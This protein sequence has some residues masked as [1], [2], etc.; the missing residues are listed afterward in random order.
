MSFTQVFGGTTLYPSNVSYLALALT[1]DTSLEWPLESNTLTPVAASIIDVSPTGAYAVSMP[2]AT[3]TGVGQTVLF[4][5]LGP[6]TI[7]IKDAGGGTLLSIAAGTQWEVYLVDNTSAAGTWRTFQLGATTAQAQASA[8]AGFGLIATGSTLSVAESVTTFNSNFTLPA[9]ARGAAY[10]WNG[11]LGTVS[12]IA[13][14]TL[15][16]NWFAD[17]RNSGSGNLTIDPA[18]SELINGAATL[19]LSP[20]DS[21]RVVTDGSAWYTFGLGRSAVFAFDY[22][23]ISLTG[24]TSP[25]TLSGSEL[26]RVAYKFTGVLTA[27]M[28]I[29]VPSTTQQYWVDNSTTGGSYTL[30]L[31]TVSQTPAINVVRGSRGIF[32]CDGTNFLDADTGSIATPIG[33]S[34]G[35]TGSTT[36]GGAR[37]NLSAA[38]SGANSDITSL[39]GLTTAL[40]PAYGGTGV[41]TVPS[42]GQVLIGNGTN[43]TAATLTAGSNITIT[44][45]SGAITIAATGGGGGGGGTVTSVAASGGTTGMSFTGSPITTSGTLT[46]TGTLATANGGTGVTGTPSNGQLLIGNGSG[47]TLATLTAGS[48]V[49]ITNS[50]GGITIAATGGGGGGGTVTSVSGSGGSTGL[51]LSGGPITTSGTLTLGGT[52]ALANGGTGATTASGARTALDVPSTTGSGAS[53]TWGISISGNAA[54]ATS[55]TS[56]TS[57]TTATTANALSAT[58]GIAGGGTGAITAGAARTALDVPSTTGSGASG[59]WGISISGNAATATSAT[60]ATTATTATTANALNTSNSYTMAGLTVNGA[61]TATGNITAYFSDDRLKQ[62]LGPILDP[63][64]KV[65][66]LKGFYYR[67]NAT[68]EALG[69]ESKREVGVSAQDVEAVMPEVVAPAPIDDRYL[70]LDYSRLVPLLIEAIKVQ[71]EQIDDLHA[72]IIDLESLR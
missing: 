59:T 38:A 4:N 48:N 61:I 45:A 19:V 64:A 60:S 2:D 42:N 70:T 37:V 32:Y 66:A 65:K 3:L 69:Y 67:A 46:L 13:A 26:N 9:G 56:A 30:G 47:Y 55:A 24:Q 34:D 28:E 53:G 50:A 25:Y 16:N 17:I 35:G 6:S 36:A 39:S 49:T 10:V 54:T 23:S 57:A 27:N 71:Q 18:S 62:R 31:R 51:T 11:A 58:L 8:L 1:A 68:A 44:N 40:A 33:I 12:L 7:T 43:Y 22:T 72:R 52:L 14:S 29:V 15:G 21:C 41:T 20:G 63:I 5:N